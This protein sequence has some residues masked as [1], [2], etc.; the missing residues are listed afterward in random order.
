MSSRSPKPEPKPI[1]IQNPMGDSDEEAAAPEGQTPDQSEQEQQEQQEPGTTGGGSPAEYV[2]PQDAIFI[3]M[4]LKKEMVDGDMDAFILGWCTNAHNSAWLEYS[5]LTC[6]LI[7]TS[8]LMIQNPATT[9]SDDTLHII[10]IMDYILT[11][12]A[13]TRPL[14]AAQSGPTV[15]VHPRSSS[16]TSPPRLSQIIFTVEMFT[17]IIAMDFYNPAYIEGSPIYRSH[18]DQELGRVNLPR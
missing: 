10:M 18:R 13:H 2:S 5:I 6:I 4:G 7:N 14:P 3:K 12:S 17:H 9:L 15:C 1:Q 8:L 11:V 16:F